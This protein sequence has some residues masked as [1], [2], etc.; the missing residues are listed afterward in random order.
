MNRRDLLKLIG[1]APF[2]KVK[3]EKHTAKPP[4]K[5]A[6]VNPDVDP[7]IES[8]NGLFITSYVGDT[9]IFFTDKV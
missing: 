3:G 9:P 2:V 1:I 7:T 4:D 5:K 8:G 6:V